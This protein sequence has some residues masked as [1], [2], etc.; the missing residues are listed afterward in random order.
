M[1]TLNCTID[2]TALLLVTNSASAW[3]LMT[4]LS[5]WQS[6]V[7]LWRVALMM[8][9]PWKS[10]GFALMARRM[11]V[12]SSTVQRGGQ[13]RRLG[14]NGLSRTRSQAKVVQAFAQ[15]VGKFFTKCVGDHGPA[16]VVR[17]SIRT[18]FK[19]NCAGQVARD[20]ESQ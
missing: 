7:G 13:Q 17:E 11:P 10:Q 4:K 14:T 19:T 9:L 2:T 1:L 18:H 3:P 16:Q 12:A 15:L 6:L 8:G 5:E 20:K